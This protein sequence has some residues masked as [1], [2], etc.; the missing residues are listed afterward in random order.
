MNS[1]AYDSIVFGMGCFWGAE[2]RMAALEGVI[3]TESGYAG[4]DDLLTDY[5][6]VLDLEKHLR[7]GLAE[8]RNHAEVVKVVYDPKKVSLM[9]LLAQFWE[10]HNPTQGDRQ[11]NDIGS[12]YRS[13]I[14]YQTAQQRNLAE[15]SLDCYQQALSAAGWSKIT[16]EILPLRNYN[17]AEEYHQDY[18]QKHPGGY[19]GLGGTGIAFPIETCTVVQVNESP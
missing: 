4:G 1:P 17:R 18:L 9:A 19:C 15:H 7:S 16:T 8:K 11:G 6:Q 14:Y 3:D 10:N 2:K 5:H 12:N 13:A